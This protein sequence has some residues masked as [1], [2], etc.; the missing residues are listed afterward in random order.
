M[1]RKNSSKGHKAFSNAGGFFLFDIAARIHPEHSGLGTKPPVMPEALM[2]YTIYH[3]LDFERRSRLQ[4]SDSNIG[5]RI[6]IINKGACSGKYA[7]GASSH[8]AK[9]GVRAW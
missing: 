3:L 9:I 8:T 4:V 6:T 5:W 2:L 1:V 7:I